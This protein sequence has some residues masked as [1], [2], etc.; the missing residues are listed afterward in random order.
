MVYEA[1]THKMD[2]FSSIRQNNLRWL[3]ELIND[4]SD[5]NI[6]NKFQDNVTPLIMAAK[7]GRLQLVRLLIKNGAKLGVY[8]NNEK[9]FFDYLTEDEKDNLLKEFPDLESKLELELDT[10]KYNL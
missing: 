3:E 1:M 6:T 8:D 9:T 4:G 5:I 10:K 2:I 7:A